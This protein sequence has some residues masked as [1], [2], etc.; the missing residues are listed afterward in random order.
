M[1]IYPW[2]NIHRTFSCIFYVIFVLYLCAKS[3]L[4]YH[5][6]LRCWKILA[7]QYMIFFEIYISLGTRDIRRKLYYVKRKFIFVCCCWFFF[8]IFFILVQNTESVYVRGTW[9]CVNTLCMY[10]CM[11]VRHI[12]FHIY[13]RKLAKKNKKFYMRESGS[14]NTTFECQRYDFGRWNSIEIVKQIFK[15]KF[16]LF[17]GT[18]IST[19]AVL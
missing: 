14:L 13:V 16:F 7:L 11:S 9:Y 6:I 18:V 15:R 19:E 8:F 10:V 5:R 2:W 17:A 12:K 4:I 1:Y 3:G